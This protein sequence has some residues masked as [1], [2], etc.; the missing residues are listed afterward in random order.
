MKP[1][2]VQAGRTHV[3]R[4]RASPDTARVSRMA[5]V[6]RTNSASEINISAGQRSALYLP[7]GHRKTYKIKI[8]VR[9]SAFISF[10]RDKF[11][12]F[13]CSIVCLLF[14]TFQCK[15]HY[16]SKTEVLILALY[17]Y[18]YLLHPFD[19]NHI[20]YFFNV[21]LFCIISKHDLTTVIHQKR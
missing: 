8:D 2:G 1:P 7:L 19:L 9:C 5:A 11:V 6:A 21:V 14:C 20:Q 15:L 16:G 4:S 3:V 13:I 17:M 12:F 10:T 18:R